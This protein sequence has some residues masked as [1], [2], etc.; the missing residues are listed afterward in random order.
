MTNAQ[1]YLAL[2][3]PV[4]LN[5]AMFGLLMA[6]MNAKFDAVNQRFE[7]INRRFDD[8]RDLWRTELRRVEDVIDARRKHLEEQH[9]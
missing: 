7:G 5:A 2:G 6:Y 1:L 4:L 3:V 8:M 9:G